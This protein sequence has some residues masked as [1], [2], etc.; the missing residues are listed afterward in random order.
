MPIIKDN[1]AG[2]LRE[3]DRLISDGLKEITPEVVSMAKI[4]VPVVSGDL[5]RSIEGKVVDKKAIIGS[6]LAY[7]EKI[8]TNQPY[9]R[10][11][12][13]ANKTKIRETF[14]AK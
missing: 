9:L 10:P 7:A 13:E 6:P 8:E 5:Q 4:L 11:A 12:L 3:V 14:R 2:V 1:T